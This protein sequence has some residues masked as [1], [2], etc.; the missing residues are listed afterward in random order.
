[1]HSGWDHE[2]LAIRPFIHRGPHNQARAG[3]TLVEA[4]V[5]LAI[6]AAAFGVIAQ[7]AATQLRNWSRGRDGAA[8]LDM[9]TTGTSQVAR[10]LRQ[11]LPVPSRREPGAP[12]LFR[13]EPNRLLFASATG[14][15]PGDLGVEIILIEAKAEQDGVLLLRSR[16]SLANG[17]DGTM[18]NS[19]VLMKGRFTVRFGY[20]DHTGRPS[21]TWIDRPNLPAAVVMDLQRTDAGAVLGGPHIFA[22]PVDYSADCLDPDRAAKGGDERCGRSGTA[23]L[24]VPSPGGQR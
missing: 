3:F 23:P 16:S 1:M 7:L 19:V 18:G 6:A 22:L 8:M 15:R 2:S 10:D 14:L 9:L 12:V 17:L 4:L 5:A 13:G 11:T 24:G 21:A 20:R